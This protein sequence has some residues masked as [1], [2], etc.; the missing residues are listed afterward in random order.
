[1]VLLAVIAVLI[2]EGLVKEEEEKEEGKK[3]TLIF[4]LKSGEMN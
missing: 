1:M 4:D 2:E 3:Y